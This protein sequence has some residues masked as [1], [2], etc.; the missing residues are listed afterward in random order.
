MSVTFIIKG[1]SFIHLCGTI[2]FLVTYAHQTRIHL[3]DRLVEVAAG[4]G[5]KE[6][7]VLALV[8]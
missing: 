2:S 1:H 3:L 5:Y 8:R 7:V 6:C 4:S